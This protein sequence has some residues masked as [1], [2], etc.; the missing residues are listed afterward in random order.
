[1]IK[2]LESWGERLLSLFVPRVEA[3][4]ACTP[5]GRWKG[6]GYCARDYAC[7]S[8]YAVALKYEERKPSCQWYTVVPCSDG[9]VGPCC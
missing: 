9:I 2:H 7:S 4:A 6:C 3:A 8:T 5:A 1:M